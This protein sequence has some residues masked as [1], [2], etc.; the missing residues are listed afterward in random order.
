L[1][2]CITGTSGVQLDEVVENAG[3]REFWRTTDCP[4][5]AF[6]GSSAMISEGVRSLLDG[7]DGG[8]LRLGLKR[9]ERLPDDTT[10]SAT[11]RNFISGR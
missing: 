10:R 11:A 6:T 1:A 5:V 7:G 2:D 4:E 3:Q 9:S 8:L